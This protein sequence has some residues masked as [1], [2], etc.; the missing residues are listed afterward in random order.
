MQFWL[1]NYVGFHVAWV[2]SLKK[3]CFCLSI[4]VFP[5]L[6]TYKYN[7]T[8]NNSVVW[9]FLS[10]MEAVKSG[11]GP[12]PLS[13]QCALQQATGILCNLSHILYLQYELLLSDRRFENLKGLR[14]HL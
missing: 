14:I 2:G 8:Q 6:S 4:F 13:E 7:Y 3:S 1:Y 5:V 12:Q 11:A 9:K 10:K